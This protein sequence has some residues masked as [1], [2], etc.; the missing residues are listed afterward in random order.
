MV[1]ALARGF[2]ALVGLLALALFA[3]TWFDLPRISARLGPVAPGPLA[4]ATLRADMGGFFAAWAIGALGAAWRDD[5][6]L[7]LLPMLLLGLA[8]AGRLYTYAL[9]P[10]AAIVP[11]M[12]VEAVLF[13][14]IGLARTQLG[15]RR[16]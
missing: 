7:A 10:D 12:T 6:T 16:R 13:V 14:A 3:L 8:F 11:P 4:A 5:R 9:T 1:K 15:R 2:L